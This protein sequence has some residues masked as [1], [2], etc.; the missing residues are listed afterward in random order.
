MALVFLRF[1]KLVLILNSL[2]ALFRKN[3]SCHSLPGSGQPWLVGL[4]S[5]AD[6]EPDVKSTRKPKP[7][8]A[9]KGTR[10]R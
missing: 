4:P 9:Q 10:I 2:L 1:W 5:D 3:F 6:R 7:R 8:S